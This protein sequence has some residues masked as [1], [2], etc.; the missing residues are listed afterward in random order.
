MFYSYIELLRINKPMGFL[1]LFFPCVVSI[2]LAY[3]NPNSFPSHEILFFAVGSFLMRSAGCIINDYFDKNID[4][5]VDRTKHRPLASGRISVF[6]AFILLYMFLLIALTLLLQLNFLTIKIGVFSLLL[7][8]I[9]PLMKR[10]TWWPQLFLGITFNIGALMAWTSIRGEIN[11]IVVLLY[12]S[13]IFW[14]LAYDTIYG[15]QDIKDDILRGVKST[16]IK[17]R[18]YSKFFISFCYIIFILFL[19]SIGFLLKLSFL[20]YIFLFCICSV[21]L[22]QVLMLKVDEPKNCKNAFNLGFFVGLFLIL[23][24]VLDKF[25]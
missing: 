9:Y 5:S 12:I 10:I 19:F 21:L 20:Y 4:A 8:F 7:I 1:L 14:T 11:V 16:S 13:F 15:Y 6:N 25:I 17:F 23:G 22:L 18:N 2:L 24:I 3:D